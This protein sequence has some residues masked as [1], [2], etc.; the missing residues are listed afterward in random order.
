MSQLPPQVGWLR[1]PGRQLGMAHQRGILALSAILLVTTSLLEGPSLAADGKGDRA[2]AL[3]DYYEKACIREGWEKLTIQVGD[4]QRKI[5][6][7][8]P[9]GAWTHGAIIAMHGGG[10][11]YSFRRKYLLKTR[12]RRRI[13]TAPA[14]KRTSG[15]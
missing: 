5:L 6:W 15:R 9:K 14:A 8:G 13:K 3:Y 10:G 4:R 1:V 7:R 2:Q 12:N 11:T